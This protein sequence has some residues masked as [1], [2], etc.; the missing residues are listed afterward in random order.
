[1]PLALLTK[2][3]PS[4]KGIMLQIWDQTLS[5][6]RPILMALLRPEAGFHANWVFNCLAHPVLN[7]VVSR[8]QLEVGIRR[9]LEPWD[10]PR[11]GWVLRWVPLVGCVVTWPVDLYLLKAQ[12]QLGC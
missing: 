1:M 9:P 7:Y 2:I 12:G 5:S 11:V 4:L 3:G 6:A 8:T 10:R